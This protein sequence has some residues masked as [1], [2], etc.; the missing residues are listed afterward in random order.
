[1]F[2]IRKINTLHC[3]T[4]HKIKNLAY[5]VKYYKINS[6]HLYLNLKLI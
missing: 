6:Y 1:M 5:L 4:L 3:A 2:N